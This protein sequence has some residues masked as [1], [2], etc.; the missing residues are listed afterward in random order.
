MLSALTQF[1][2]SGP[3]RSGPK[4]HVVF[5][6]DDTALAGHCLGH[7]AI[8]PPPAAAP[9]AATPN[10][11][12]RS[13]NTTFRRHGRRSWVSASRPRGSRPGLRPLGRPSHGGDQQW[14]RQNAS[15]ALGSP[16]LHSCPEKSSTQPARPPHYSYSTAASTPNPAFRLAGL[17]RCRV[18]PRSPT[19]HLARLGQIA[20]TRMRTNLPA[21]SP[22]PA[23]H[24]RIVL[25]L[26]LSITPLSKAGCSARPP[27][28]SRQRGKRRRPSAPTA[29][30]RS[31]P[32]T[33]PRAGRARIRRVPFP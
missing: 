33:A 1:H 29:S 9:T 13:C 31:S 23:E 6:R 3:G 19:V 22:T 12:P 15:P 8:P 17:P 26:D 4:L 20:N 18:A 14:K 16:R 11:I 32:A 21:H 25:R 10:R 28:F 27:P 24:E 30:E 7:M 2:V 5:R